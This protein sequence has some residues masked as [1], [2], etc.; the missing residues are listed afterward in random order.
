[1]EAADVLFGMERR[2]S[3]LYSWRASQTIC[4]I[5]EEVKMGT[6]VGLAAAS[7]VVGRAALGADRFSR[8]AVDR[9]LR[10]TLQVAEVQLLALQ[11]LLQ[12]LHRSRTR[13]IITH[14]ERLAKKNLHTAA[15]ILDGLR[16]HVEPALSLEAQKALLLL[17]LAEGDIDQA[18]VA[19]PQRHDP[20]KLHAKKEQANRRVREAEL[21]LVQL[22]QELWEP[23]VSTVVALHCWVGHV[24]RQVLGRLRSEPSRPP[25]RFARPMIVG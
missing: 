7:R 24:H 1:M 9:N 25:R 13:P 12:S 4:D 5:N 14:E 3:T 17:V 18:R 11:G 8:V 23:E 2:E 19:F 10:Q 6:E 15:D 20:R 22:R 21:G 16:A